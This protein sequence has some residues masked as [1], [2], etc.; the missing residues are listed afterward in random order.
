DSIKGV[1]VG[2]LLFIFSFP[3]LWVNE[4][5]TDLSQVAKKAQVVKA[6]SVGK[7][8]E[9]K[10]VSLTGELRSDEKVGDPQ[11]LQP[12]AYVRLQRVSEMFAWV[13]RKETDTK[14]QLGGSKRTETTYSYDTAWTESPK[15]SPSFRY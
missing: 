13:E 5:R 8:T 7:G 1:A 3:V 10:L 15:E 12:G 11:F 2:G 4:G 6:D 14:K 9:G